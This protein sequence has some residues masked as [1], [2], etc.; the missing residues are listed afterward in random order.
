MKLGYDNTQVMLH[1]HCRVLQYVMA[2]SNTWVGPQ[3][4][5]KD[6]GRAAEPHLR[7]YGGLALESCRN[8]QNW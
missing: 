8:V 3:Q 2:H 4:R 6:A 1:G 7:V 5:L